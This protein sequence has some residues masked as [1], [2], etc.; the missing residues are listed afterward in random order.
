VSLRLRLFVLFGALLALLGAA[1]LVLV[2]SLTRRLDANVGEVAGAV[3]KRLVRFIGDGLPPIPPPTADAA[4][5]PHVFVYQSE[6]RHVDAS[7]K[8]ETTVRVETTD[9]DAPGG[10]RAHVLRLHGPNVDTTI[11]IPEGG[12][13]ST[14]G[15]F[16]GQLLLGSLG[17][18]GLGLLVAAVVADRVSSPLHELARTARRVGEGELDARVPVRASGEVG[19]AI[20]SFNRMSERLAT[21]EKEALLV[22][23]RQHLGELGDVA[24]GLAHALRNPIHAI[25]LSLDELAGLSEAPGST[26]IAE[27]AR[28]Q[29]RRVDESIRSF[30]ALAS[31]ATGA[32]ERVDAGAL[33]EDV[34]LSALQDARGRVRVE[35][36]APEAPCTLLG[37]PAEVRAVVQALVVNAVEASPDGALVKVRVAP[38]APGRCTVTVEDEGAGLPQDVRTRLFQPHVTTKATGSG[39]GLFLA[40]RIASTRY[41]GSVNLEDLEP[42]GTRA[43]LM[44]ADREAS[45]ARVA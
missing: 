24:R 7:G 45:E 40:Q 10:K 18:L 22:K 42:R 11:P 28:R 19:E 39:M 21:L 38:S 9:P 31:G 5:Q 41:A 36:E 29:I 6:T 32:V 4:H 2:R 8:V 1:E 3:G 26:E 14:L 25:G 27:T 15:A 16:R 17:I 23:E 33:V 44:L 20:D 13:G 43:V 37:I 35:V 12:L 30:L 34:V